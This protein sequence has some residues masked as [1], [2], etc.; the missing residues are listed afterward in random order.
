MTPTPTT[1][2]SQSSSRPELVTT[3]VT[4]PSAP[5]K[6]SSSSPPYSSI[7]WSSSTPWKKRA[8]SL[9]NWRSSATSS[10]ITIEHLTPYAAVSEAATSQ[11]M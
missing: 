5:S 1:T 6:R 4:R 10:S 9:P 8:I 7:P 3:F 2:K 11:P